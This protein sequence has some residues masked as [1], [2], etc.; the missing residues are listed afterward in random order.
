MKKILL[1]TILLSSTTMFSQVITG[2]YSKGL[3][4]GWKETL[5][6]NGFNANIGSPS[7][8]SCASRI[9]TYDYSSGYRCGVQQASKLIPKLEENEKN[10]YSQKIDSHIKKLGGNIPNSNALANKLT[11]SENNNSENYQREQRLK[12]VQNFNQEMINQQQLS[13]QKY[14]QEYE[15]SIGQLS[16]GMDNFTNQMQALV[17]QNIMK[18]LQRRKEIA[19]N[20]ITEHSNRLNKITN[21]YN[22]IESKKFQKI[23]NG[24]YNANIIFKQKFSFSNNNELQT[25]YDCKVEVENNDLKNI[26]LFGKKG[27]EMNYPHENI[28]NKIHNGFI[29]YYDIKNL[30]ET[31]IVILEPYLKP[32]S[33]TLISNIGTGYI[34]IWSKDKNDIGKKIYVQELDDRGNVIYE[35][36][37]L[38]VYAKNSKEIEKNQ[39]I[40]K[41]SINSNN[42]LFYFGEITS[43]PYG[44][45]P[46]FP[47]VS[48]E[49]NKPLN[50]NEM[51]FVEIKKY[52][53]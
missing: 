25:V 10:K 39:Q 19:N 45:F 35:T 32:N 41:I 26:Y 27:F 11:S 3:W 29:K 6:T 4:E 15:R 13:A 34:V 38:I 5:E 46:L 33:N 16:R 51:R 49:N 21:L 2:E 47:K 17:I 20:F 40:N 42:A 50:N 1:F 44:R 30:T 52:R 24:I 36:T 31:S 43:T 28:D 22:Q 53:E 18:E 37:T 8:S 14:N 9:E 7:S 48:K 23:L 12:D